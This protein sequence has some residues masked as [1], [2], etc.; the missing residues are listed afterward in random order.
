MIYDI[1]TTIISHTYKNITFN[2]FKLIN[3][4]IKEISL[5]IDIIEPYYAD[6]LLLNFSIIKGELPEISYNNLPSPSPPF[7]YSSSGYRLNN[8]YYWS[9]YISNINSY[10]YF[11]N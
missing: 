9:Y 8:R 1:N 3:L 5:Y 4:N 2:D 10:N 7:T 6:G 11:F